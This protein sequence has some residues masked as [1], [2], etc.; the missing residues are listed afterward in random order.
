MVA[1]RL[2]S[3]HQCHKT[4]DQPSVLTVD[5]V[6]EAQYDTLFNKI[7]PALK[8]QYSNKQG[9]RTYHTWPAL[10]TPITPSQPIGRI[11]CT[12]NFPD[13]YLRLPSILNGPSAAVNEAVTAA[14]K[15]A[16]TFERPRQPTKIAPSHWGSASPSNTW[17]LGPTRVFVQNGMSIG[18]AIF[19][20]SPYSVPL[21]YNV[22]LHFPKNFFSL[23][24]NRVQHLTH[25]TY[26]QPE[27]SSQTASRSIQPFLYG[28]QILCCTMHC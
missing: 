22:P 13:S 14:A 12:H 8:T 17:S 16:D 21:L 6:S 5:I 20:S 9:N 28:S 25:G 19:A 24:R 23:L 26:G 10:C 7:S 3:Q 18:S 4:L 15:I 27:S 1:C 11:A 2:A